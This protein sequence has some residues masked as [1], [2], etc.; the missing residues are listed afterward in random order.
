[1]KSIYSVLVIFAL[2]A[3]A[4]CQPLTAMHKPVYLNA[5]GYATISEQKGR[6]EH[7]KQ[8]R[9]MRASKMDAYKE[10][11]EQVYGVRVSGRANVRDQRL[12]LEETKNSVDGII[13]GAEVVRSYKVGDSYVTE[14]RVNVE[15]MS[16]LRG[17][18]EIQQV[19]DNRQSTLY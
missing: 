13:R 8:V 14:M 11:A 15:V 18:G 7:E 6:D 2:C 12:G 10:L 9:A 5:V 4:G 17:F 16:K 3:L 19:P 1:M